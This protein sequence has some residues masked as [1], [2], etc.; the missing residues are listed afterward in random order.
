M[1]MDRT[2]KEH[3]EYR[4]KLVSQVRYSIPVGAVCDLD[5]GVVVE[6]E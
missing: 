2:D 6:E 3:E 5:T 4:R 1:M